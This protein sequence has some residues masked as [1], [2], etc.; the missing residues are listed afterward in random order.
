MQG[1]GLGRNRQRPPGNSVGPGDKFPCAQLVRGHRMH[2]IDAVMSFKERRELLGIGR[3][4]PED[5]AR[6]APWFLKR[7]SNVAGGGRHRISQ[8]AMD[9]TPVLPSPLKRRCGQLSLEHQFWI[10]HGDPPSGDDTLPPDGGPPGVA[11]CTSLMSCFEPHAARAS[12]RPYTNAFRAP[13]GDRA[14]ASRQVWSRDHIEQARLPKV[15]AGV[16]CDTTRENR[17]AVGA[18]SRPFLMPLVAPMWRSR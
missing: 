7:I 8:Q 10:P 3:S 1:G 5:H 18:G 15:A 17:P 2:G 6:L 12:A 14:R 4:Q 13:A 9:H 16:Q 11:R